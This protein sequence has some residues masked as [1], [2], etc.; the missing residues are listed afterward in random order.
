MGPFFCARKAGTG[1]ANEIPIVSFEPG[2]LIMIAFTQ[3]QAVRC[4]LSN[5]AGSLTEPSVDTFVVRIAALT[6]PGQLRALG[7]AALEQL[8]TRKRPVLITDASAADGATFDG[9]YELETMVSSLPSQVREWRHVPNGSPSLALALRRLLRVVQ[10]LGI[11]CGVYATY[12]EAFGVDVASVTDPAGS[13]SKFHGRAG[14]AEL[15]AGTLIVDLT[16]KDGTEFELALLVDSVVQATTQLLVGSVPI[17]LR[18]RSGV[19]YPPDY[20]GRQVARMQGCSGGAIVI[21]ADEEGALNLHVA[22]QGLP[23]FH[24]TTSFEDAQA[25]LNN[26]T[27]RAFRLIR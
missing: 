9:M 22:S 13:A 16:Q 23:D 19:S 14:S 25:R 3:A 8:T 27:M 17:I 15:Q 24:V 18:I 5:A 21:V 1:F 10:N 6:D 20:L 26:I 4:Y 12:A 2:I 7:M 11:D